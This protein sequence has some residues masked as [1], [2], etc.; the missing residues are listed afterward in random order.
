M[1]TYKVNNLDD[2]RLLLDREWEVKLCRGRQRKTL[3]KAISE[4]LLQ[5]NL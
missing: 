4:L 5:F 3:R 2:E 1:Q